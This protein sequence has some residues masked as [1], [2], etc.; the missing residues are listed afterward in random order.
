MESVTRLVERHAELATGQPTERIAEVPRALAVTATYLLSEEG[1]KASLLAGGNGRAL[2][3]L[4]IQVPAN[5]LHLVGVDKQGVARLKLRP[6]YELGDDQRVTRA[7]AA[8]TYDAPP[9]LEELFR[10][11]ARNHELERAFSAE[12]TAERSKRRES[13]RDSR[14]QLAQAFLADPAQRALAHPAPSPRRCLLQAER[15]RVLFDVSSDEGL[16]KQVPAEAHRRFRADLRARDEQNLQQRAAQLAVHEEKKRFIADWIAAHGTEEQRVRQT[17]GVLPMAEAVDA[18]ADH[19]FA[20]LADRPIYRRDGPE[21]LQA[22]LRKQTGDV[23]VVVA[24][25]DL[26]LLNTNAVKATAEQWAM[27][28]EIQAAVPDARVT[29][30]EHRL[31]SKR[32]ARVPALVIFGVLVSKRVGP[33]VVR[34]EYDARD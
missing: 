21:R 34:R 19:E 28:Q 13:A 18:I 30:R 9:S 29:L 24:P 25:A 1:R 15:G 27:V 33:F 16:A 31:S 8:P 20:S 4:K 2:Q 22:Y 14:E 32:H 17:A 7:D 11:A 6:R 12:R 3:D 10:A 26:G 23:D 5:R